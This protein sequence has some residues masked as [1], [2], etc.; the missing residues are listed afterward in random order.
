MIWKNP[1]LHFIRKHLSNFLAYWFLNFQI[2]PS[3]PN[4]L[5]FGDSTLPSFFIK[6]GG[7]CCWNDVKMAFTHGC[8]CEVCLKIGSAVFSRN[9]YKDTIFF[10]RSPERMLHFILTNMNPFYF[11]VRLGWNHTWNSKQEDKMLTI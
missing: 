6:I 10:N 9:L 3:T 7:N 1:N 11:M 4:Y 5:P 2:T 8:L